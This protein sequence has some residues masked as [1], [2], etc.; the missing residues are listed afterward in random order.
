MIHFNPPECPAED[1]R[2]D[3]LLSN[4]ANNMMPFADI[5]A[6]EIDISICAM[7]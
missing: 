1:G 6:D 5:L 2:A 7:L 4:S 3:N